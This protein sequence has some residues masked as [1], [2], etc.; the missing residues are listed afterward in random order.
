MRLRRRE[1]QIVALI[2]ADFDAG[3]IAYV[4][5]IKE[6]SVRCAMKQACDRTGLRREQIVLSW[7]RRYYPR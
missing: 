2:A 4:L 7:L 6:V 5:G 3:D 1:Q